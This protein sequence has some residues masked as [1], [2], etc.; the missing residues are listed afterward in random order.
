MREGS[1]EE[2]QDQITHSLWQQLY[3]ISV[4]YNQEAQIKL[5]THAQEI[6]CFL[7]GPRRIL[8]QN[9]LPFIIIVLENSHLLISHLLRLETRN[10]CRFAV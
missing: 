8:H 10:A 4:G 3:R 2:S 9:V 1:R 6:V 5:L 7:P